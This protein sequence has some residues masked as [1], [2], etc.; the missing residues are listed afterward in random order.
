MTL[1]KLAVPL[2]ALSLM[3]EHSQAKEPQAGRNT[4]PV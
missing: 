3:N 2:L 4:R 1:F